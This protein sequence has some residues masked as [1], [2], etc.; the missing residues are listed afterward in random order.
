MGHLQSIDWPA[1]GVA[2]CFSG[3]QGGVSAPPF[4]SF[5]L[6]DHVG[7]RPE[8]V[9]INRQ[10]LAEAIQ[11]RPV[12]LKQVH[13]WQACE[14]SEQTKDGTEA[15][16]CVSRQPLLA[17]LIMVADCLPILLSDH[18]GRVVAAAHAGWKGL[19]G[20]QGQ[21]VIE[22]AVRAM[23]LSD[24]SLA[25]AWLGPC[26][27]P[28]SFEVGPEVRQAFVDADAGA[29]D[30]FSVHPSH[31]GQFLAD[32]PGLARLRLSYLGINRVFGND[33]SN[34]W[35]TVIQSEQYFSHRRDRVSGRQAACIW[36]KKN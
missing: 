23:K 3:R 26:I 30:F 18:Q 28:K 12:F 4:Q 2:A 15:D 1:D 16:A 11:A 14:L 29:A 17:C 13:G 36:L 34:D 21:G 31:A 19:L 24:S 27:G 22:S 9:Q 35:C 8:H 20:Q 6:G 25:T 33:G 32:L 7:D 10:H 5:N